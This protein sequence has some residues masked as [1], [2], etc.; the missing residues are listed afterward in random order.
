MER[1]T[2]INSALKHTHKYSR[3]VNVHYNFMS[4]SV[5]IDL[6]ARQPDGRIPQNDSLETEIIQI[7]LL[8]SLGNS[9]LDGSFAKVI[10]VLTCI[11]PQPTDGL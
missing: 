4:G 6:H 2:N 3:K 1:N 10:D 7:V 8:Q 5:V 9:W 11:G